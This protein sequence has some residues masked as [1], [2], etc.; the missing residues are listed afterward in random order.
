MTSQRNEWCDEYETLPVQGI[1][2]IKQ[3]TQCQLHA[4]L[5][6]KQTH[7]Q[8]AE[9]PQYLVGWGSFLRRDGKPFQQGDLV[10]QAEADQLLRMHLQQVSLPV[11]KALP[12]WYDLNKNQQGALLSFAHSIENDRSILSPRS[13]LG[14]ALHHRRWY[15]VPTILSGYYGPNPSD[16][17]AYRRQEE[18][19]LFLA[20][21]R[22][23][24][25]TVINRSRLLGLSKP[26]LM[27]QD[28]QQ[29]QTV[30]VERG[31]E[32]DVDGIFG[33]ITQWAIEKFQAEVGLPIDGIAD[34]ATQRILFARALFMSTPYLIG[35]DVREVQS[36]LARI[37]Y[38]VNVNGIFNLRTLQ[39]VVA[40]Q[41]YLG[42]PEDGILK[43]KALARL[44]YLPTAATVS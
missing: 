25:Y 18:A 11:L 4:C 12:H 39:A 16:Y 34:V 1:E 35:S 14:I 21:I 15:Q 13:L 33:P 28:V 44:L 22:S 2:L 9:E 24:S 20:E 30:L 37:G 6:P 19:K 38:A 10:S 40:F 31:Y 23:D 36:L 8:K 7:L 5:A 41:K 29:L 26:P 3:F 43:G 27:G 42:L 32:I 17:I